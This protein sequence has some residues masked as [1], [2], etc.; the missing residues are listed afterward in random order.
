[1]YRI[2]SKQMMFV[3]FGWLIV[4]LFSLAYSLPNIL[5]V[6]L[7]ASSIPGVAWLLLNALLWNPVW[8]WFWR[9]FPILGKLIFPDL[10]G[11][12]RVELAS[13]WPRQQQLLDAAASK[14]V[15]LDMRQCSSDQLAPLTPVV[16][17]AE[18]T[19]TWWSFEMKMWNPKGNTPIDRSDTI[20]VDPFPKKGLLAPGICY[21][22]KQVNATDNVSDD[23][24]FYGAA[25]L[26]YD[27]SKDQLS[28]LAWTAR[29]WRRAMN[30][31]GPVTFKRLKP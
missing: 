15:V 25:R 6:E 18:I 5:S 19:Q 26:E 28:G 9:K 4:G 2:L 27:G 23:N 14:S 29:M 21:F 16:L 7:R 1:M 17:E 24:E 22:Y 31:A 3:G 30:T 12:W 8:R 13:N 11:R 10:N 20:S